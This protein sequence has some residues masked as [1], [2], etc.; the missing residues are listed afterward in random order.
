MFETG[1]HAQLF[2]LAPARKISDVQCRASLQLDLSKVAPSQ[3]PRP[4][5]TEVWGGG[6]PAVV[7]FRN[8]TL[9]GGQKKTGLCPR[10]PNPTSPRCASAGCLGAMGGQEL[11]WGCGVAARLWQPTAPALI[12]LEQLSKEGLHT[13][14][15]P[16]ETPPR[17]E[18][19]VPTPGA[20]PNRRPPSSPARP[21]P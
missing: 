2:R 10:G 19:F 13:G 16:V 14:Q 8:P 3:N 1:D 15:G 20:E 9:G 6:E 12:P 21:R 18:C 4:I 7:R 17:G 11:V 5:P